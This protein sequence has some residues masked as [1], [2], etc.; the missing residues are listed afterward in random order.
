MFEDNGFWS[1][2]VSFLFG[3]LTF[4]LLVFLSFSGLKFYFNSFLKDFIFS[5]VLVILAFLIVKY[6]KRFLHP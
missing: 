6:Y 5:V 2:F 1:F 4:R 3:F